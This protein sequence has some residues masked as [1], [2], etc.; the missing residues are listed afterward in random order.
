MISVTAGSAVLGCACLIVLFR[1]IC[2]RLRLHRRFGNDASQPLLAANAN[3]AIEQRITSMNRSSFPYHDITDADK[4]HTS[5][6]I[7]LEAFVNDEEVSV[8]CFLGL[9][10]TTSFNDI[11]YP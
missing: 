10:E 8:L 4:H 1:Y 6:M 9:S 2:L 5:C 11:V 3:A 7:C